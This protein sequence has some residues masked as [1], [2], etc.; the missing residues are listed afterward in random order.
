MLFHSRASVPRFNND[1]SIFSLNDIRSV[2]EDSR[3]WFRNTLTKAIHHVFSPLTIGFISPVGVSCV[4]NVVADGYHVQA[5]F[6]VISSCDRLKF[7]NR[8]SVFHQ[9]SVSLT[10]VRNDSRVTICYLRLSIVMPSRVF[11]PSSF[12]RKIGNR[13]ASGS[14]GAS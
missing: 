4:S 8:M 12:V 13:R 11:W 7:R 3:L 2:L 5:Y 6:V 9:S 10:F 1:S 14:P